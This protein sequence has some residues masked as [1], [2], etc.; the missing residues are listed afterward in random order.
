M[1]D[2]NDFIAERGGNPEKIRESQRKRYANVEVVD[3]VI[4]D[5]EDHRKSRLRQLLQRP[6][7]CPTDVLGFLLALYAATQLNG[8]INAVQKQI[9]PKKKVRPTAISHSGRPQSN[10]NLPSRP[11]KMSPIF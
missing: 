10:P 11:R 2:V 5:W 6:P 4:A 7:R 9:A 8:E 1:L 3:E